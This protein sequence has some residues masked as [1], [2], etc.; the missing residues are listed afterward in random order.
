M[1][2]HKKK[3]IK[4]EFDKIEQKLIK[5]ASSKY[6]NYEEKQRYTLSLSE[7][8]LEAVERFRKESSLEING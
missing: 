1:P 6:M 5:N 7:K 2:A 8:Y 4:R 3:I